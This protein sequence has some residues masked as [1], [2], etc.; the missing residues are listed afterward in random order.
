[1]RIDANTPLTQGAVTQA[2]P[3]QRR[4]MLERAVNEVVGSMFYRPMLQ[5]ARENPFKTDLMHGGRGEDI[6][7]AQLDSELARRAAVGSRSS[8]TDAIVR[9]LDKGHDRGQE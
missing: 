8:L 3:A 5:M 4:A 1:M 6:F 2:N 9:R 7:A